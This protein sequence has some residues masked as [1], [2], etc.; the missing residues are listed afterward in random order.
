MA[1]L[2]LDKYLANSGRGSRSQVKT[3]LK[4]GLV[5]V[6]GTVEKNG[7]RKIDPRRDAVLFG[8]D[9]PVRYEEDLLEKYIMLH[10][11]AGC[12]C[13]VRDNVHRTVMEYLPEQ[14]RRGLSPVGR[15]DLDT[16][17]LLLLTDD[18]MLSHNLLSPRH[19]VE[20]RYEAVIDKELTPESCRQFTRGLDIGDGRLTMPARLE[21]VPDRKNTWIV[22]ICEGRYHQ[23]KRM[24]LALGANVTALK[25]L[26]MGPLTLDPALKPGEYRP[27][28]REEL[29][30]LK[31]LTT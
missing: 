9:D 22:T 15:L 13:A 21:P 10:K 2:R 30:Q 8:Q 16:E 12:V 27:L 20:K 31:A 6:N 5:K 18:G 19:H 25:R 1:Q 17:G 7:G 28:T 23:V 14:L 4:K 11:P 29:E 26:S 3:A 24:F